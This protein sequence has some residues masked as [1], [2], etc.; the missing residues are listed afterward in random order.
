MKTEG[1]SIKTAARESGVTPFVIRAWERRYRAIAPLRTDSNQRRY[2]QENIIRLTKLRQLVEQGYRIGDVAH[3]S[4]VELDRLL[5]S[6]RGRPVVMVADPIAGDVSDQ[7]DLPDLSADANAYIAQALDLIQ[8]M[9]EAGL[10]TLLSRASIA[11]SVPDLVDTVILPLTK[12]VGDRWHTGRFRIS[13]EHMATWVIKSVLSGLLRSLRTSSTAP[14]MVVTTPSGQRH[15]IGAL[16]V[17]IS[18]AHCG[19]NVTYLGPDL[20][21]EEI[22][23]MVLKTRSSL[24][25][26]SMVYPPDDPHLP[27]ELSR[28][29]HLIPRSVTVIAG[30]VAASKNKAILQNLGISLHESLGYFRDFLKRF[31]DEM[32]RKS[33]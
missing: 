17:A 31:R 3:M 12:A 24:V 32:P 16:A 15:E 13:Q 26:L 18:G 5:P 4:D 20:P 19:W 21:A 6:G 8:D 28:L 22:A 10:E 30:G 23:A 27:D 7:V 9:N 2:T 14:M 25:A 33:H 29:M 11:M 1:F